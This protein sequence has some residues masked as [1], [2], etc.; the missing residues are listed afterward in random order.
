MTEERLEL[1]GDDVLVNLAKKIGIRSKSDWSRKHL[2]SSII[3][4]MDEDRIEK[5]SLLN[6][7]VSI[8]SKKY[9]V[10]I[11]EELDLSY[12]VDEE[13]VLPSRYNDNMLHFLLR[14]NSWGF[15]LWDIKDSLSLK[16][17]NSLGTVSYILR[18]IELTQPKYDKDAIVDFFDIAVESKEKRRYVNLPNEQSYYCVELYI[19]SEMKEILIERSCILKTSRDHVNYILNDDE[20]TKKIVELSGFSNIDVVTK[21]S[22]SLN[23]ILP[24]DHLEEEL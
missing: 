19:A 6:L 13:M 8:E 21:K 12:D 15:I 1:L 11:D 4:A 5:E 2:I 18:V 7:A 24:M 9:S 16:Y 14:D 17:K 22:R 20:K 10:T 23:R 3:D